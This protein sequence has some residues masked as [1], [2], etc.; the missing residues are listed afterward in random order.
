MS[1]TAT[2][3]SFSVSDRTASAD[4]RPDATSSSILTPA[5]LTHLEGA[6]PERVLDALLAV[7]LEA[8]PLDMEHD[9][10]RRD[11]DGPGDLDGTVDVL[12][13]DFLLLAADRDLAGR[14]EAFDVLA[15]DRDERPV[16]LPAGQPLGALDRLRD[17]ADGLVDVDDDTLLQ[18]GR[19]DRAVAHDRHLAVAAD[20]ADQGADLGRADIDPDQDRFS[21]HCR[22]PCLLLGACRPSCGGPGWACRWS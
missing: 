14:V 20:L 13:A 7:D 19:G 21:L 6:H 5:A 8:P 17:R 4:A 1:A 11:R 9:L 2:P 3:S 15:T 10:A 16:D 12:A 18:A 22:R